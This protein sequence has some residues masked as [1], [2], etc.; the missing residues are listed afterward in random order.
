MLTIIKASIEYLRYLERCITDLKADNTAARQGSISQPT[1]SAVPTPQPT[2]VVD[3]PM[4]HE[5]DDDQEM[6][7]THHST[8]ASTPNG[9]LLSH[10]Q[11]RES[12]PSLT[13]LPSLSHYGH[14]SPAIAPSEAS[15]SRHYSISSASAPSFSPYIHSQQASPF[16]APTA[17]Q[18]EPAPFALTSPAL[19]PQDSSMHQRPGVVGEDARLRDRREKDLDREAMAALLMLNSDR[20]TFKDKSGRGM[21]V[22]D[23][24]SN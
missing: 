24:L 10:T 2:A 23:L 17:G 4:E 3:Q 21:S 18:H 14:K 16:F 11:S 1:V 7:D 8:G 12:I 9:P 15:S 20:R 22:Q 5:E 6:S 19:R 13:S